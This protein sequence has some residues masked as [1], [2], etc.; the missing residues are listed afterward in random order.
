MKTNMKISPYC[1]NLNRD[2]MLSI[3]D[4]I[5]TMP[6]NIWDQREDPNWSAHTP[7]NA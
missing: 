3:S 4:R 6:N 5:H 7:H 2:G 1:A